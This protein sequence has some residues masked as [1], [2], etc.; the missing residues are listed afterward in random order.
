MVHQM[1][2]D[3]DRLAQL[4]A[5]ANPWWE[6]GRVPPGQ[7]PPYRRRDFYVLRRRLDQKPITA[8]T[9]PRQV[10]KTTLMHQVIQELLDD[11]VRSQDILYVS[12]DLPGLELVSDDPLSGSIRIFEERVLGEPLSGLRH[13]V[14][15]FIDEI[16]KGDHWDRR[17]KGWY[18]LHYN[19]RF[20]VTSSSG[21]ELNKGLGAS[22]VGRASTQLLLSWKF[23]DVLALRTGTRPPDVLGARAALSEAVA[24]RDAQRLYS[25]LR[26]RRP[27]GGASRLASRRSLDWYLLVNGYP[28]LI[29]ESDPAYC[30]KRLDDYVKLTLIHDLYRFYNIRATTRVLED[31]LA[32]LAGQSG[33]LTSYRSIAE[34]LG[35][36]E[37]TLS[38]YLDYLEGAYLISR[39]SF[40]SG[41]RSTR[42]R[43]QKKIYIPN[44]G[45]LNVLRGRV[46]K[47]VLADSTEVG[48]I[49]ET[50][51]HTDAKRLAFNLSPGLSPEVF[52]WR[53]RHGHEVDVVIN[54]GKTPLPIEVKYRNNPRQALDGIRHFIAEKS[55]PFGLVVNRDVLA[56]EPPLLYLPL[57]DFL[58]MT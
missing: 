7:A 25:R 28:E 35:L 39:A 54:V 29:Q 49:V 31:L 40:Y 38:Q 18:D 22:L 47:A 56:L 13:P 55:A 33:G 42:G 44:A 20:L 46:D 34:T 21:I 50:V 14:F 45:L 43:R 57:E 17:L 8:L 48:A 58:L 11:G 27:R 10:G 36:E 2:D 5:D 37:R 30:A 23:V 41:S 52:Y 1:P 19:L 26:A 6:S 9:G 16:T 4:L 12:F 24:N 53:D 32:L 3:P 51:V 15:I